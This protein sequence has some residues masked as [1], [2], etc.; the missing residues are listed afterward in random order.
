MGFCALCESVRGHRERDMEK[1]RKK[2]EKKMRR[3]GSDRER[4]C[5]RC[6]RGRK[7]HHCVNMA[8]FL[9]KTEDNK[10]RQINSYKYDFC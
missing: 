9:V 10:T 7:T 5:D 4:A 8:V 3:Q 2:A 6:S 1:E